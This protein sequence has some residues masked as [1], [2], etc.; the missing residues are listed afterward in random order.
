MAPF[1]E[2]M[3]TGELRAYKAMVGFDTVNAHPEDMDTHL[4]SAIWT[5]QV[6]VIVYLSMLKTEVRKTSPHV[7]P[8]NIKGVSLLAII[9]LG[10]SEVGNGLM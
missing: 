6:N 5:N 10:R 7:W 2:L 8:C 1:A 9:H 3:K 4:D